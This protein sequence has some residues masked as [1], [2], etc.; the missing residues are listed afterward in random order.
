[1]R[2]TANAFIRTTTIAVMACATVATLAGCGTSGTTTA[3]ADRQSQV[4]DAGASVMPFDLNKTMHSFVKNDGGGMETVVSLDVNDSEQID[5]VRSHL[6][7]VSVAFAAGN[8]DDPT[9]IHGS[10]MPGLQSLKDNDSKLLIAYTDV[11]GGAMITY[12]S[13]DPAVVSAIH[14]WFDAQLADHGTDAMSMPTDQQMTKE[15]WAMHHP[16]QPYPGDSSTTS[17]PH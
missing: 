17:T 3:P 6:N 5:L 16:G 14:D 11:P 12:S 15:M 8:F 1:M 4:R 7:E 10:D 9:A 2:P 13:S